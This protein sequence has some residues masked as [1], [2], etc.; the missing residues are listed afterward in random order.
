MSK[1]PIYLDYQATTPVDERVFGAMRSYFTEKFGNAASAHAYGIEAD[2]AVKTA[3]EGLLKSLGADASGARPEQG[4][5]IEGARPEPACPEFDRRV[6]GSLIFTSGAT[7]SNNLVIKG[8]AALSQRP[9]HFLSQKTEH[10]CV[11]K[12]LE[13]MQRQ[14]HEVTLLDVDAMGKIS[15]ED[16]QKSLRKNT[17]LVSIMHANNEIGTIQD[18]KRLAQITHEHSHALFHTDAAQSFGKIPVDV[19]DLNVDFLTCSAHKLYGPKGIGALYIAPR[20][21]KLHL[22]PLLHGGGHE[23]GLR[24]GT[25]NVPAIVGFAKAVELCFT[26]REKEVRRLSAMRN[27]V[28]I[29]L[30]TELDFVLLNGD[31]K[32]RLPGNIN[33]CFEFVDADELMLKLPN[34]A[35]A[36][37]SA[38]S[39]GSTEPS[40]VLQAIGRTR[41]QAKASL[42]IGLGRFTTEAEIQIATKEIIAE[43]QKLREGS[44]A[45][46]MR[47]NGT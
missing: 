44:L 35:V 12:S 45:Y 11:L 9:A 2:Y 10:E 37:G 36:S 22:H 8:L 24:S 46:Q 47:R 38:C 21:P 40:Y 19:K 13:E 39:A 28:I 29:D 42:R 15:P 1:R 16:L 32:D 20:K 26:E 5:G 23:F 7:E 25:V 17:V 30:K 43:V 27:Q 34:L 31:P 6:E 4:R 41:E 3:R 18:I 33:L 14:G